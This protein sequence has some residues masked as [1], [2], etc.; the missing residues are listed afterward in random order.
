MHASPCISN[1]TGAKVNHCGVIE[2]QCRYH[3]SLLRGNNYNTDGMKNHH[4]LSTV[5]LEGSILLI[6][7]EA[8]PAKFW[9][10]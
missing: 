9:W 8:S 5:E 2:L 6:L 10:A 4:E 7:R 3:L 1:V